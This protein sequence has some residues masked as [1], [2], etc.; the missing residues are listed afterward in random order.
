M[1]NKLRTINQINNT[2]LQLGQ[3]YHKL[4]SSYSNLKSKHKIQQNKK[5]QISELQQNNKYTAENI[6]TFSKLEQH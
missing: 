4:L 6:L 1:F 5:H 2:H 3:K